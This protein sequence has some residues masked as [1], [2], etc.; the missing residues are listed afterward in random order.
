MGILAIFPASGKLGSSIC[1]YL[2]K[3]LDPKGLILISRHPEKTPPHLLDAGIIARRADYNDV[4]SLQAVFKGASALVLISYPSIEKEHRF[5][6][7][8]AAIDAA[9]H[10]SVTRIFYTSL[11]FGGDCTP[12]SVAH[13]MQAHLLTEKYLK[14]LGEDPGA[15]PFSFTVVREGIYSES[16]PMY[17]GFPILDHLANPE[18]NKDFELRIPHDGLGPGVAWASI[19]DLGEASAR[20]IKARM[21]NPGHL[22]NEIIL[23]SGPY[24]WSI[25]ETMNLLGQITGKSIHLK[26]VNVDEYVEQPIVKQRLGSHGPEI[27]VPW[28]W[29]TTFEAL[30]HGECAVSSLILER[31]LGRKPVPLEKTIGRMLD[32]LV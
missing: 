26:K 29:A 12:D 23:L 18:V 22:N 5:H 19:D 1:T 24:V 9:R 20:L 4:E 17:T 13:V 27:Q 8:K 21:D 14:E 28:Q 30:K 3:L 7:H 31:L 16:F 11:A 32:T 25:E 6:C 10:C 15:A 2:S